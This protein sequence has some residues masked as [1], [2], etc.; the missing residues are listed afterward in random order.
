MCNAVVN[1]AK[2]H[3]LVKEIKE[4]LEKSDE[5]KKEASSK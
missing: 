5:Q 2:I 4:Y 1:C 3:S